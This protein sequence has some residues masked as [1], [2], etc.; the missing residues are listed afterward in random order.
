MGAAVDIMGEIRRYFVVRMEGLWENREFLDSE[1]S[2][3]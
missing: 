2:Q 1:M 3:L